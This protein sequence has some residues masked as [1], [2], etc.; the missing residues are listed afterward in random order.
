MKY[1]PFRAPLTHLGLSTALCGVLLHSSSRNT[2]PCALN[3]LSGPP[4]SCLGNGVSHRVR[5]E[6]MEIRGS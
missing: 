1:D 5:D 6:E 4:R 2:G 3:W